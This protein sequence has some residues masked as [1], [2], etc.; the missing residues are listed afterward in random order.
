M[1]RGSRP[2]AL[3]ILLAAIV[4]NCSPRLISTD[5]AAGGSREAIRLINGY[6]ES[7]RT[8]RRIFS[9]DARRKLGGIRGE[10]ILLYVG[11]SL[12]RLEVWDEMG[13]LIF[14]YVENS[15]E[16]E[17][18][19]PEGTEA[20]FALDENGDAMISSTGFTLSELK[21]IGLSAFSFAEEEED[22][23]VGSDGDVLMSL[24]SESGHLQKQLSFDGESGIPTRFRV[25]A[26]GKTLRE[27]SF[28]NMKDVQDI[29]RPMRIEIV[30][31][32][33]STRVKLLVQQELIN[34]SIPDSL[35]SLSEVG[36]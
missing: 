24:V 32:E 15:D 35:F 11:P 14:H 30:D 36:R 26:D 7:I 10:G 23:S 18:L 33:N 4:A 34:E 19:I 6:R 9:I 16:H 12:Y 2:W 29:T 13:N 3:S 1:S 31:H 21:S 27:A 17:L 22:L 25:T 5:R 20:V 28:G 8:C